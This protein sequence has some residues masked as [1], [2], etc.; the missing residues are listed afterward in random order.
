MVADAVVFLKIAP[1]RMAGPE[2][3]GQIAVVARALVFIGDIK[4]NG[5]ACCA[6]FEHA[7]KQAHPVRLPAFGGCGALAGL[8]QVQ[9]GLNV[10]L[11][12][13]QAR[14]TAVQYAAQAGPVGFA[15]R[16]QA[17]NA[18]ESVARHG[19]ALSA[20]VPVKMSG[21]RT[22]RGQHAKRLG[23]LFWLMGLLGLALRWRGPSATGPV[24]QYIK[25]SGHWQGSGIS[26]A[27]RV[28]RHA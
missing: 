3:F 8:A 16:G 28:A 27:G 7:G 2:D 1:V 26:R 24:S 19:Y 10:R 17:Q 23:K 15:E 20:A 4:G 11:A 18:P 14:R 13:L 21:K 6:A 5:R 9:V 25:G 22:G 12:Q